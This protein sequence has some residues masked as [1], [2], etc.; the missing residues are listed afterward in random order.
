LS[1]VVRREAVARRSISWPGDHQPECRDRDGTGRPPATEITRQLGR[2]PGGR[3][4]SAF[5]E[6]A[7]PLDGQPGS[8]VQPDVVDVTPLPIFSWLKRPDNRVF[9]RVIVFCGVPVLRAIATAYVPA[10][11]T[12]AQM[13]PRGSDFQAFLASVR[14]WADVL[15]FFDMFTGCGHSRVTSR[16]WSNEQS[17]QPDRAVTL[18]P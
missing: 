10:A 16:L 6:L 11:E 3:S 12:Q 14:T 13:Y 8:L 7:L 18:I 9:C 1:S 4:Q 17:E 15:D 2:E 5:A